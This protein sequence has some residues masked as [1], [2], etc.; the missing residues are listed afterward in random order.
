MVLRCTEEY[1]D[2][3]A[4]ADWINYFRV[5]SLTFPTVFDIKRKKIRTVATLRSEGGGK[6][7]YLEMRRG[8]GGNRREK[9]EA[10]S[11]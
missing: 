9:G 5:Q 11:E 6:E 3:A 1:D 4:S 7:E 10:V 2:A 8:E